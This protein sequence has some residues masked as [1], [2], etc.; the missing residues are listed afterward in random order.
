LNQRRHIETVLGL[1]SGAAHARE[2]H[3]AGRDG[4]IEDSWRRCIDVHGLDPTAPQPARILPGYELREHQERVEEFTR[5]ARDGLIQLYRQVAGVGYV[6]LLTDAQGVT[7]DYIG[8]ERSAAEL[9]RTGLYLGADWAETHAG[10]CAVGTALATGQALTVHQTDHFDVTH[11]PLTCTAVPVFDS[12]GNMSA[13]LDASALTSPAP[14]SSQQ[15]A[16]QL[17]KIFAQRIEN[18]CF[19]RAHHHDWT[20][21]LSASPAFVDVAPDILIALDAGG[22]VIGHNRQAQKL[23]ER[24]LGLQGPASQPQNGILGRAFEAIFDVSFER[25][26][27]YLSTQR[28]ERRAITLTKTGHTLFLAAV[29]PVKRPQRIIGTPTTMTDIPEPLAALT[30]GDAPLARQLQRA[31]RLVDAPINLLIHGETGTGKEYFAKALHAASARRRRPFVSVNCAAI[32][33]TLIESEL[34]GHLPGSFSGAGPNGKR[35]LIQEAD[36]GTLFLDEIGDMPHTL[37]SRLLRV[38]AEREVL[39]IGAVR[40]V[41]VD[42]HVIS[43]SHHDLEQL[44][45]DGRF[46]EDLYYRLKGALFSLP[47]L[48]ERSDLD[49]LI[50]K[51][52]GAGVRVEPAARARLADHN[53]PGNLRELHNVLAYARAVCNQDIIRVADLPDDFARAEPIALS[54][55]A[56][57]SSPAPAV[58]PTTAAPLAESHRQ[59]PSDAAALIQALCAAGWN[60]SAAARTLGISRMTLYRRMKRCGVRSPN[61]I[62]QDDLM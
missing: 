7:V 1:T 14:K 53:W 54:A 61:Q 15:F 58:V 4:L 26:G 42:I 48:R 2:V 17:V 37:Q 22:R 62:S 47:P 55:P 23:L 59:P 25:L 20:L 52:L 27:N 33:E 56:A 40:P 31:A 13:V 35:G 45:R 39:A 44:V 24:E 57:A 38:L 12:Q 19:M 11:I 49:W 60:V 34:F 46:R 36:G 9:M 16:L 28:P 8:D 41:Q 29:P 6:I 43:A 21:H 18:A 3:A 5:I 30:G 10:T 32:P 50:G 51:L